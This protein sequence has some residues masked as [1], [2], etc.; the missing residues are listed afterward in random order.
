MNIKLTFQL[1]VLSSI[2]IVLTLLFQW[3]I[4]TKFGPSVETDA[5]FAGMTVPQLILSVISSSLTSV[6]VPLFAGKSA[7]QSHHDAWVFFV[8]VGGSFSLF[9]L[10]LHLT[11]P[12]WVPLLVPGFSRVGQLLTIQLTCIQ[13]IGMVFTALSGVQSAVYN[14]R[15]QFLH[16]ELFSTLSIVVSFLL[17]IWAL[18]RFGIVA[19]AWSTA[20]RYTIQAAVMMPVMGKFV[21][22]NF[23]APALQDAWR[24]LKNL[25][26]VTTFYKT[27]PLIDR[28]LL[29]MSEA[30]SLSIFYLGQQIYG[31]INTVLAKAVVAP[32]IT[33]LSVLH[34]SGDKSGYRILYRKILLRT[35]LTAFLIMALFSLIGKFLIGILVE[36]GAFRTNNVSLLWLVMLGLSGFFVGGLGGQITTSAYYARGDTRTPTILGIACFMLFIPLKIIAFY[37]WGVLGIAI[38]TSVYYV[39]SFLF[40]IVY[41]R[42]APGPCSLNLSSSTNKASQ[43]MRI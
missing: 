1:G 2:S 31:T 33:H 8:L 4:F 7:E 18:P 28:Y 9:A 13:L 3:V 5:L 11:A 27:E 20:L 37:F 26:I 35:I 25:L 38:V 10:L 32:L 34:K 19:A 12:W 14:A 30:G 23:K 41:L 29:S 22:P 15:Q 16:A 6:L 39:T 42:K 21:M 40:Q 24:R 17:L 36:W 43:G